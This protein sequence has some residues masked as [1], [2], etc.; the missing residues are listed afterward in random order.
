MQ[1]GKEGRV[2]DLITVSNDGIRQITAHLMD[3]EFIL[4]YKKKSGIV[5]L[6]SLIF[7]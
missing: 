7:F 5:V 3:I 1:Q 6:A 4:R 2:C